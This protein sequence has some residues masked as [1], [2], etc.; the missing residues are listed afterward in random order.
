MLLRSDD[1]ALGIAHRHRPWWTVWYGRH[2]R[3]Y[4][5]MPR[6]LA[7]TRARLI[8]E[9]TPEALE[10]AIANFETFNPKPTRRTAR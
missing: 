3:Q 4:W 5:A 2:T 9:S 8:D 10:A 7:P 6:W 1:I